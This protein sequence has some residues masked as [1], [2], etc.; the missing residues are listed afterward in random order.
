MDEKTKYEL[1]AKYLSRECSNDEKEQVETWINADHNNKAE[2]DKYAKVWTASRMEYENWDTNKALK[3]VNEMIDKTE[4]Q[5]KPT[6]LRKPVLNVLRYAA[7]FLIIFA[8]ALI[9]NEII[10]DLPDPVFTEVQVPAGTTGE[11]VFPDNSKVKLDAGSFLSYSDQYGGKSREVE[12]HGEGY[13]EVVA[14]PD[15][16]FVIKAEGSIIKVVGTKFNVRAWRSSNQVRVVVKEGKVS[17]RSESSND[18]QAVIIAGNQMSVISENGKPQ[19]PQNVEVEQ[20]LNWM[21]REMYFDDVPLNEILD[22]LER[23][24][25]ISIR[26]VEPSLMT[27]KLT[28]RLAEGDS[29]GQYINLISSIL[30]LEYE[31]SETEYILRGR[32]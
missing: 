3:K 17:L 6:I 30:G 2:F 15:S 14:N 27:N 25:N 12:L 11:I 22:Q 26:V 31:L 13:F 10:F 32:N 24:Y 18:D 8:S 28:V 4:S 7:V 21:D 5:R 16:P 29:V 9:V 1:L 20:Y 19:T 23:W